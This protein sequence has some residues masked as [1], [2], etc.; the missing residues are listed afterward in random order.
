MPIMLPARRAQFVFCLSVG[1][2]YG[3]CFYCYAAFTA[4]AIET[5]LCSYNCEIHSV[6]D[7][8]IPRTVTHASLATMNVPRNFS[9]GPSEN[10]AESEIYTYCMHTSMWLSA[11][12]S[13]D[14]L[15]ADLHVH[16]RTACIVK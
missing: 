10:P 7:A 13:Y 4:H 3:F 8:T 12:L 2:L 14:S 16:I 15:T 5:L 11:N 6:V 9:W 1:H